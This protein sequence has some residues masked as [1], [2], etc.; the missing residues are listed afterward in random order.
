MAHP[1]ATA[2]AS[3][4][5]AYDLALR[6][7]GPDTLV[8]VLGAGD[9][10]S[11]AH[12]LAAIVRS[13]AIAATVPFA[14]RGRSGPVSALAR[15]GA[16]AAEQVPLGRHTSLRVGGPARRFLSSTDLAALARL[17]DAAREDGVPAL[18]LGGGTNLLIADEGYDG[19]VVRTPAS[20]TPSRPSP[21]IG[22]WCGP[23]PA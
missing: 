7:L 18:V 3:L 4:D 22:C 19:V 1:D 23:P 16:D 8:V 13:G 6:S 9:V 5:A 15:L 11:L 10:T 14:A 2:A 20:A 12:R 21:A 17:L